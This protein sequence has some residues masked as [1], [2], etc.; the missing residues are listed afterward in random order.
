MDGDVDIVGLITTYNA[1][2]DRV[3]MHAVRLELVDAQAESLNLPLL[4]VPLPWPCTN[5]EY[6]SAMREALSLASKHHGVT[7]L[8]HGDLFLEDVRHYR[9]KFMETTALKPMFPLWGKA[10]RQL[11]KEMVDAGVRARIT[12]LDPEKL[13]STFA[14]RTFDNNFLADLPEDVDPCGEWGEFHT[15]IYKGPMFKRSIHIKAGEVVN[16]DGFVFSDLMAA[17][18]H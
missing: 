4:K 10:T 15:F 17:P 3:A 14:G 18:A 12:C 7:H 6:E 8:A 5:E 16:R 2:F 1:E 11:A 9:E 13:P